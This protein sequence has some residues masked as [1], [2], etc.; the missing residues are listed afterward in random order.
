MK[1]AQRTEVPNRLTP[2]Q[3]VARVL[4]GVIVSIGL[5]VG[6]DVYVH[7]IVHDIQFVMGSMRGPELW[8]I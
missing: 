2:G 8:H 6:S 4:H 1:P 7:G 5:R 3:V